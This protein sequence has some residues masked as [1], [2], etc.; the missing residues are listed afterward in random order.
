MTDRMITLTPTDDVCGGCNT[1]VEKQDGLGGL[2]VYCKLTYQ[3]VSSDHP[4]CEY[5][6]GGGKSQ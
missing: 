3:R 5:K 2:I 1:M 4:A 6:N